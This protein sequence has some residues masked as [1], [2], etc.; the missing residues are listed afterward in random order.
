M[1]HARSVTL[2]RGWE[3]RGLRP[4]GRPS[5]Y[6]DLRKAVAQA[7]GEPPVKLEPMARFTWKKALTL[8]GAFAVIYLVLPQLANAG[9]SITTRSGDSFAPPG[10]P[11]PK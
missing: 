8:L 7:A 3:R 4:G 5:L 11:S 6:R 1:N 9:A 2:T 10:P